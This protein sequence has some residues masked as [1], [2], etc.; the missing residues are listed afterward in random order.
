MAR[1]FTQCRSP[2]AKTG[3]AIPIPT[4]TGCTEDRLREASADHGFAF[5][6]WR[7]QVLIGTAPGVA[8]NPVIPIGAYAAITRER[9]LPF[10]MPG[11]GNAIW[12]LVDAGLLA[13]GDGLGR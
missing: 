3:R 12:E 6:I 11:S 1:T 7:P 5:T 9:G 2:C 13:E 4:S 10:A 8:M